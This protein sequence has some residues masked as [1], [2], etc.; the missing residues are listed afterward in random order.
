MKLCVGMFLPWRLRALPTRLAGTDL[1]RHMP[2]F[3]RC[4]GREWH[5]VREFMMKGRVG[6]ASFNDVA[7]RRR[8]G[9]AEGPYEAILAATQRRWL[10]A[11]LAG[12]LAQSCSFGKLAIHPS[13]YLPAETELQT[14]QLFQHFFNC[15]QT[16]RCRNDD[17]F[18]WS[19]DVA[20][21]LAPKKG[22]SRACRQLPAPYLLCVPDL[23]LMTGNI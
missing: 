12:A 5:I 16:R 6:A 1:L 23:S 4:A 14:T 13:R 8:T 21:W 22:P 18:D 11:S 9:R 7:H 10:A 3:R 19:A 2:G 20:N 17:A 15:E